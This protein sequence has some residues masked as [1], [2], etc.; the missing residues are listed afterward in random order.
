MMGINIWQCIYEIKLYSHQGLIFVVRLGL[1]NFL[2]T[3]ILFTGIYCYDLK[4][5]NYWLLVMKSFHN[6]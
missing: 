6:I 2:G 3:G 1:V 5:V 4:T